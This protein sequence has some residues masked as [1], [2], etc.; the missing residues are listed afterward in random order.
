MAD[1]IS[2]KQRS[3]VMAQVPSKNTS[4][5]LVVRKYLS[6]KGL[7]YRTN[8]ANMPG[9]P[10]VYTKKYNTAIF[11]NG[12]FWHGHKGCKRA[13]IPTSRS[14]YWLK[15]ISN[16]MQ[17]DREARNRLRRIGVRV[18]T[19]WGCKLTGKSSEAALEKLFEQI[20]AKRK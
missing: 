16:N 17:R 13:T 7:R 6:S 15:K 5:E 18:I 20:Q 1:V 4:L 10:D 2:K 8:C 14:S 19:I 9:K 11:V 3:Y 12:C